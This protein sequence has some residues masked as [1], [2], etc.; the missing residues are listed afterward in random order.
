MTR[1]LLH[2]QKY[3]TFEHSGDYTWFN[4]QRQISHKGLVLFPFPIV[5]S[6]WCVPRKKYSTLVWTISH[7]GS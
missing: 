4:V 5:L 6:L 1:S 2:Q 7:I 3:A